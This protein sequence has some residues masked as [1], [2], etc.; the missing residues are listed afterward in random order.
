MI[1][2]NVE[3]FLSTVQQY[4]SSKGIYELE[5]GSTGWVF[6]ELFRPAV[7][8]AIERAI[9][10]NKRMNDYCRQMFDAVSTASQVG[11]PT[12]TRTKTVVELD[13]V[14]YGVI[15]NNLEDGLDVATVASLNQQIQSFIELGLKAVGASPE[16]HV[17]SLT[18]D[19]GILVFESATAAH[20]FAEAV[21]N[22]SR[23]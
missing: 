21:H 14:G 3:E 17:M 13:L 20:Q 1:A 8:K 23:T 9:A 12:Q 7:D 18:G 19:G 4:V 15:S 22:Y 16:E 11:E 5:K 6:I 10:Y 2:P